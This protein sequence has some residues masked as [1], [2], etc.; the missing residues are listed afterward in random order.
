MVFSFFSAFL[1]IGIL[2]N[3]E[4]L[5]RDTQNV[6]KQSIVR[7]RMSQRDRKR[8]KE[9]E[10]QQKQEAIKMERRI[11]AMNTLYRLNIDIVV[12]RV[13]ICVQ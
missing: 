13:I 7:R 12:R 3:L 4:V 11:A 9:G 10:T 8:D 6:N 1:F 5:R 2:Y